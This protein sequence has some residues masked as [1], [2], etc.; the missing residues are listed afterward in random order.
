MFIVSVTYEDFDFDI[1]NR[2]RVFIIKVWRTYMSYDMT[3][4]TIKLITY[5][6]NYKTTYFYFWNK[7]FLNYYII[8][9][10]SEIKKRILLSS[11]LN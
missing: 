3:P 1:L 9:F 6:D 8:N 7:N 4:V 2:Y 10:K 11:K 5:R